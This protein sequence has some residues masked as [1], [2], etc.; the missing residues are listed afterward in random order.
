[1]SCLFADPHVDTLVAIVVEG[2][3]DE[4]ARRTG[5]QIPALPIPGIMPSHR[6]ANVVSIVHLRGRRYAPM[7]QPR[8]VLLHTVITIKEVNDRGAC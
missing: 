6:L 2:V 8:A 3:D 7:R 5:E 1:M 4:G